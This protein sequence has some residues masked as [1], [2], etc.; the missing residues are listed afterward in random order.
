MF[1][2]AEKIRR[3]GWSL[4]RSSW[5]RNEGRELEFPKQGLWSPWGHR[6]QAGDIGCGGGG[7]KRETDSQ[8]H[9]DLEV[10]IMVALHV[11]KDLS[12]THFQNGLF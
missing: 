10:G 4:R 1:D 9:L 11:A 2:T 6:R 12:I 5:V 8:S 3:A 7:K